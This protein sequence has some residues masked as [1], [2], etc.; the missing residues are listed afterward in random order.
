MR[1]QQ[2]VGKTPEEIKEQVKKKYT[3]IALRRGAK[4]ESC[5]EPS[6]C[7]GKK[8]VDLRITM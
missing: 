1:E 2:A 4:Q 3:E 7:G 8:P 6:C 5:C